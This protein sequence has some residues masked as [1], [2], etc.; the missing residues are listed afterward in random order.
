MN[1]VCAD[2]LYRVGGRK[3]RKVLSHGFYFLCEAGSEVR[4]QRRIPSRGQTQLTMGT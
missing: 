2:M 1:V 3:L 4:A